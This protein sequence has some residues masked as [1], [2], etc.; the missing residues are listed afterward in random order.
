[1]YRLG[2]KKLRTP[3]QYFPV[4][5]TFEAVHS[6]VYERIKIQGDK[7]TVPNLGNLK[8]DDFG[9]V[10]KRLRWESG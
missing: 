10:E 2:G 7:Y 6:S 3:G 9:K 5:E 4:E 1:M 8:T